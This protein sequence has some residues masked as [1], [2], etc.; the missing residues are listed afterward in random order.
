M[1]CGKK[2]KTELGFASPETRVRPGPYAEVF[3]D[4]S[5]LEVMGVLS[6]ASTRASLG[7]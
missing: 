3:L 7:S 5:A 1:L 2:W 4:F 6:D